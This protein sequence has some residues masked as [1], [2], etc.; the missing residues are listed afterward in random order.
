MHNQRGSITIH[1]ALALM[2]VLAFAAM[3]IDQGVFYVSRRQVQNAADAGALAAAVTLLNDPSATSEA[4]IAAQALASANV[5]WGEATANADI[6][7]S[8]LPF[9][10][11]D[12]ALSCARVDVMRGQPDRNGTSHSN[13]IPTYMMRIVGPTQQGVRATATAQVAAGNAVQCIKPWVV[14]DKWVDNSGTGSNTAG[15]DQLDTYN[16]G[17]DTYS[18]VGFKATGLGNDYG[19]ELALKEGATGTWSSGWTMEIDLGSTGSSAYRDE[20]ETCPS[21]VPTVGLYNTASSCAAKADEDPEKGCLGVKTGMSQGPTQQGVHTLVALDSSATWNSAT[22]SVQGGCMA[23]GTCSNPTG[24]NISP[25]IVPIAIF[26][27]SAYV[28]S[29]CSGTNCVAQVVNL[30]GF[31]V[32]GMCDEVYP[33]AGSRPAYCGSNSEA[34]K[35]VIGRL[36]NYPGQFSGISGSAGPSTFLKVTRLIR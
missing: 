32:Q 12:G 22:S 31:F 36:M 19:L 7:V 14:A 6:V 23:T 5:V 35:T 1:V 10:C 2:G 34:S 3:V 11:P 15:W 29:G 26:N 28:A 30:L 33:S 20:I 17:T 16:P 4:R 24:V 21:Y 27:T 13:S 9:A 8:A 25:R 18:P